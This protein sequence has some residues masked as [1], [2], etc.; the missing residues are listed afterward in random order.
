[1]LEYAR[2]SGSRS[3]PS[4]AV[5][6]VMSMTPKESRGE[7]VESDDDDR[8]HEGDDGDDD[9]DSFL[10][11]TSFGELRDSR[12][13]SAL[14]DGSADALKYVLKSENFGV[15]W[16]WTQLPDALQAAELL[17][18]DPTDAGTLYG[19]APDCLA[20]STDKGNSWGPCITADGLEGSFS[21]L[22]IK[23]SRTMI[24]LR[25]GN[26]VPLRTKDGGA[27]WQPLTSAARIS[28]SGY[29][30]SGS[31][32]WSGNTLELHGRD[33][34]APLRGMYGGF[35][36]KSSDDGDTWVDESGD[37]QTMGINAGQW[38]G[39]D[40]YLTTSGEGILAKRNFDA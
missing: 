36:W 34:G 6:T 10:T 32:S 26:D 38:Y 33:L 40:F 29:S 13:K 35:V 19:V 22:I 18:V 16:T 12:H 24:L 14:R 30:R 17:A 31:Y 28:T 4:G 1:V 27:S 8:Q 25:S 7:S 3:E 39:K 20:K 23:D 21:S 5:Y 2:I 15:D 9:E 37:L 11:Y